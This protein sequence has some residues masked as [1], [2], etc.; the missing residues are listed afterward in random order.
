M[1]GLKILGIDVGSV[2]VAVVIADSKGKISHHDYAFHRGE[3]KSCLMAMLEK[4]DLADIEAVT[5]TS[6]TPSFVFRNTSHDP[7]VAVMEAARRFQPEARNLLIIGGEKFGLVS[8]DENGNYKNFKA[9]TSCAAG[10]G[11][12]LDQQAGRLNLPGIAEL[13]SKAAENTGSAPQIATRC[14]VFAKTDLI[15]AQQKGYSLSEICDGL[16]IGLAKNICDTVFKNGKAEEP[17]AICG[18]VSRN[19]SVVRHI[20]EI[21]GAKP[22]IHEYAH[23]F[24][25][26][27]AIYLHIKEQGPS[28]NVPENLAGFF[29]EDNTT[30]SE[31]D[32]LYPPL[33]LILSEYPDFASVD[34]RYFRTSENNDN[35]KG[36]EVDVYVSPQKGAVY[37]TLMGIDIGSTS[38]KAV[39]VDKK[40]GEVLAGFYTRTAGQPLAA[41]QDIFTAADNLYAAAGSSLEIKGCATTG[42]G[43]KFIGGIIGADQIIDEITA[44][45]RAAGELKPDVDTIIEIGGQDAKFTKLRNGMVTGATM[46]NVCAA[47]TGSFVEEQARKLGCPIAEFSPRTLGRK[48]PM[49][50]DRCTVFMERDLNHFLSKGH[51]KDTVLASVVHSVR[52]NYLMKVAT[53]SAIGEV[54]L[55]QG[56]TAKNKALVAAFEQHLKKPIIV[57]KYC[58]LTGALGS[59]LILRDEMASSTVFK[60]LEA[61]MKKIP[62]SGEVCQLCSNHC[63]I[64]VAE[65][66]GEK[67]AYG[68]LCGRDYETKSYVRKEKKGL[69]LTKTRK[70]IQRETARKYQPGPEPSTN[71][72]IGIPAGLHMYED[73]D[74][75][76]AFF[77][78]LGI[79]TIT[80]EGLKDPVKK[81][82]LLT[83]AE[84]CAPVT[85]FHGHVDR[86]LDN[87]DYVFLPVYIEEKQ[88]SRDIR[89]QYCY[90]TQFSHSLVHPVAEEK[91][92]R[93]LAPLVKYL[94]SRFHA[95]M[96]LYK[97]LRSIPGLNPGFMEVS[98]ALDNAM[99]L[100]AETAAAL[101]KHLRE[102]LEDKKEDVKVVLLGRPYT[103]LSESMNCGIPDIFSTLGV[104]ALYQDM[105]PEKNEGSNDRLK[106]KSS[107][108]SSF[109]ISPLLNEI[110][111]E[112][113]SRILA[114]ARQVAETDGLY[115]V[116]MTSFKC[117][118]DSFTV[119]YF[120]KIMN[121]FDK[122]YLILE[123]DEHDS[124]VGYET[125]TEASIRAFRN[126]LKT[127]ANASVKQPDI[128]FI[129]PDHAESIKGKTVVIPNWD[130]ICCRLIAA[131]LRREGVDARV[132]KESDTTIRESL[133]YNT[134]QCIP[135]TAIAEGFRSHVKENRIPPE[136]AVL[137]LS[138]ST[139]SCNIK[140]YPHHVK[141]VLNAMGGG[142]E[143]AG[144]YVG[145][146]SLADISLR[147]C[148]GT[149]FA[150][151][152]GGLLRKAALKIRPYESVKG[153]TD[154]I[155][156]ICTNRLESAFS[157]ELTRERAVIETVALL[158]SIKTEKTFQKP[159][160][161]IFGDMYTRDN[162]V[163]NQ[164][165]VR[166]IEENGGEV[167]STPYSEY[168][169]MISGTYFRKWLYE[170]QYF[171]LFTGKSLLVTL[172]RLERNY[173]ECFE[174]V[175]NEKMP[176]YEDN[177]KDILAEYGIFLENTGES[178]DNILKI[179]YLVKHHPDLSLLVQ[180]SPAL[181]CPSLVTEAM[182]DRIHKKTGVPVVVLTYDGTGGCKNSA[183]IPY[184]R[185]PK[186]VPPE[187]I[188]ADRRPLVANCS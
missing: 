2:S 31:A 171:S 122:P 13:S 118:P 104:D 179:H 100:K 136:R 178:M 5:A 113:A 102:T 70:K 109:D 93:I 170:G 169:R 22:I 103:V 50:S 29:N 1:N 64:T 141:T 77:A 20:S 130:S 89:R 116:L 163:M 95:K 138:H 54:I 51:D 18:G 84:F 38:T 28:I 153:E 167:I 33:E 68:F 59:A 144:V 86:L 47:G 85:A 112:F 75:W 110:H 123:L 45:A 182:S 139:I 135:L 79:K 121:G 160:A 157:G 37:E 148:I 71:I 83:G 150:Y 52:D 143:K 49:A 43:R 26:I 188:P 21:T 39:F 175:L 187:S 90:Y 62:V 134:G 73:L 72:T 44:H 34:S 35:E 10:T 172:K 7:Q 127:S 152:I 88:N 3:I 114:H 117:T 159:K 120:K 48:A 78:F 176:E 154:R 56:A 82:K 173:Y 131:I 168:A 61:C 126:H 151:L 8:Y 94:Y 146:L 14:A 57:S 96:E 53:E 132:M 63:K 81:G 55:F 107:D 185:Y 186:S 66:G 166:F 46:N 76:Q 145:E 147:A 40:S 16:C 19:S 74:M 30:T 6:G 99:D 12:F 156:E 23:L 4:I 15:H 80:S 65:V 17:L 165:L 181:C 105:L 180:A 32:A 125:R 106:E 162:D 174:P 58:H 101:K 119:D 91:N 108:K 164:D 177:P 137:W 87:A 69:D 42:S 25:A 142:M 161:A 60:G 155:V 27:G 128:K 183:V 9:N 149:Y 36:V 24:G 140:L 98:S 158:R 184:L 129:N 92:K 115:P 133:K 111:W 11:S 41:V 124:S 97:M 67:V